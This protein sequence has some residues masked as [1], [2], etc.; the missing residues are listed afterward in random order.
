MRHMMIK[1]LSLVMALTMI[2]GMFGAVAVSAAEHVHTKGDKVKDVAPTCVAYGYTLYKCASCGETYA[3]DILP[4]ADECQNVK[5]VPAVDATCTENAIAAGKKCEDCGEY[6]EGGKEIKDS[7]LGHDMVIRLIQPTCEKVGYVLLACSRCY[8][9]AKTVAENDAAGAVEDVLKVIPAL[10]SDGISLE[11]Q[12][13]YNYE[14]VVAPTCSDAGKATWGCIHCDEVDVKDIYVA[15][16]EAL[17]VWTEVND[18][19]TCTVAGLNGWECT[20]CYAYKSKVDVNGDGLFDM[21]DATP[22]TNHANHREINKAVDLKWLVDNGFDSVGDYVKAQTCTDDGYKWVYCLDCQT[23]VKLTLP[24]F[25]HKLPNLEDEKVEKAVLEY[26]KNKPVGDVHVDGWKIV[27]IA[28]CDKGTVIGCTNFNC[29]ATVEL[30]NALT[31]DHKHVWATEPAEGTTDPNWVV[32]PATC[33]TAGYTTVKCTKCGATELRN[34]LPAKGHK[35]VYPENANC[36]VGYTGT[37]ENGCGHTVTVA[38]Q[39]AHTL[40]VKKIAATCSTYAYDVKVCTYAGC[41]HQENITKVV[42]GQTVYGGTDY[43]AEGYNPANHSNAVVV[44]GGYTVKPTCVTEGKTTYG[45]TNCDSDKWVVTVEKLKDHTYYEVAAVEATCQN[46]GYTAGVFCT[47]CAD[48]EDSKF[49]GQSTTSITVKVNGVDTVVTGVWVSGHTQINK[50]TA[51]HSIEGATVQ[52]ERKGTCTM[53]ALTLYTCKCG[54]E[55]YEYGEK[56][57]TNHNKYIYNSLNQV[58]GG[59]Y[60]ALARPDTIAEDEHWGANLKVVDYKA[61]TCDKPGNHEYLECTECKAVVGITLYNFVADGDGSYT[62]NKTVSCKACADYINYMLLINDDVKTNDPT[63]A[64]TCDH[65]DLVLKNTGKAN[66]AVDWDKTTVK[67]TTIA[68]LGHKEVKVDA[69]VE[70]CDNVGYTEGVKCTNE[71]CPIEADANGIHWISGHTLI[72]MHDGAHDIE[73]EGVAPT[74]TTSGIKAGTYCSVCEERIT[75]ATKK[76]WYIK[77]LGHNL[78]IDN[79]WII[80][81]ADCDDIGYVAYKCTRCETNTSTWTDINGNGAVDVYWNF[82]GEIGASATTLANSEYTWFVTNYEL[83]SGHDYPEYKEADKALY[84]KDGW[85]INGVIYDKNDATVAWANTCI[86]DS[87]KYIVCKTCGEKKAVG[88]VTLATGHYYKESDGTQKPIT[89]DCTGIKNAV[90]Y[91]CSAG[92]GFAVTNATLE[93]KTTHNLVVVN[94]PATCSKPGLYYWAC[95]DCDKAF[96]PVNV[97]DEAPIYEAYASVIKAID[98][99][100]KAEVATIEHVCLA[101]IAKVDEY[102]LPTATVDGYWTYKCLTC[103]ETVKT[104][105]KANSDVAFDITVSEVAGAEFAANGSTVKV[106]IAYTAKAYKFRALQLNLEYAAGALEFQKAE[107]KA[108][109]DEA[110]AVVTDVTVAD[111]NNYGM[112]STK[113]LTVYT[114]VSKPDTTATLA[115]ED[116]A[117]VDLYFTVNY[118]VD[119]LQIFEDGDVFAYVYDEDGEIVPDYNSCDFDDFEDLEVKLTGDVEENADFNAGDLIAIMDL[120]YGTDADYNA[121]ADINKDGVVDVEDYAALK[122]FVFSKQS[123]NDYAAMVGA[124]A[125]TLPDIASIILDI[126]RVQKIDMNDDGIVNVLDVTLLYAADGSLYYYNEMITMTADDA[127]SWNLYF[128][129]VLAGGN[130]E[131]YFIASITEEVVDMYEDYLNA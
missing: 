90:G 3:D 34:I 113:N 131:Q 108:S 104:V 25:G 46:V 15:P 92:C 33:T 32:T 16:S 2:M 13:V 61:A 78:A 124:E 14:I 88:E 99:T 58:I 69:V 117:Y 56:D 18:E 22:A 73:V 109:F 120:I 102:V 103:G 19:A 82:G 129:V 41:T 91:S 12:H 39:A 114:S 8:N 121:A 89:S 94:E 20:E 63:T 1:V 44:P 37:C 27:S 70:S 9:A 87:T 106:S 72:P 95:K 62:E 10:T 31:A 130:L 128:E 83:A 48:D 97:A 107:V 125:I 93:A 85:L 110:L 116:V 5:D 122:T 118:P 40:T 112:I 115:G 6:V 43:T 47:T 57:P 11:G 79:A 86:T 49:Y 42:D 71:N 80:A 119:V 53:T 52:F 101:N 54:A 84:E 66:V 76:S 68:A 24:K 17:H 26:V 127:D 59:N 64:V 4:K 55:F 111:G 105:L 23:Y 35:M 51:K 100:K 123:A 67:A 77:P 126:F 29:D 98:W 65:I 36:M 45:C 21:K 75:D 50:N 60:S 74:C 38:P 96:Y 81:T 30:D 28:T 7:A